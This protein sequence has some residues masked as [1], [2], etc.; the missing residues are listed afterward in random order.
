[1]PI[2]SIH[3]E[4]DELKVYCA[5][6]RTEEIVKISALQLGR[7]QEIGGFHPD[8]IVLFECKTCP[9][10]EQIFRT[11][12]VTPEG[13][14]GTPHHLHRQ[15]VNALAGHLKTSGRSHPECR[16]HHEKEAAEPRDA[17]K[18]KA[19][20]VHRVPRFHDDERRD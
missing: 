4:R 20:V 16:S 7:G 5:N 8:A 18:L 3:I 17:A 13:F 1:M 14:Q 2:T 15:A 19:D 12:D 6:C 9:S 11:W 10:H